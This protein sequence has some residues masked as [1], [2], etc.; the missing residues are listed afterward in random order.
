MTI[1]NQN[2]LVFML[3]GFVMSSNKHVS[4]HQPL[5]RRVHEYMTQEH[6][7]VWDN[8]I[9]AQNFY[10]VNYNKLITYLTQNGIHHSLQ[11]KKCNPISLISLFS[12][13]RSET[14]ALAERVQ[15]DWTMNIANEFSHHSWVNVRAIICGMKRKG[16]L[17][18][19]RACVLNKVVVI[20][21]LSSIFSQSLLGAMPAIFCLVW[22]HFMVYSF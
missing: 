10:E 7:R 17:W 2:S 12:L 1:N 14:N 21:Y 8:I 3:D 18:I 13:E 16:V 9:I 15:C 5:Q 6:K 22:C 4:K 11:T 20:E 19:V